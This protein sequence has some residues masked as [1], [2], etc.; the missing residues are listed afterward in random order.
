MNAIYY[1]EQGDVCTFCKRRNSISGPT[2]NGVRVKAVS[3][4]QA[5]RASSMSKPKALFKLCKDCRD[6]L[7]VELTKIRF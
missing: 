6:S 5:S 2:D 1:N 3:M 7:L 4:E